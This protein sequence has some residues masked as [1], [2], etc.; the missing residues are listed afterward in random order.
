MLE[1]LHVIR[2]AK[3][4][5]DT[6]HLTGDIEH[7]VQARLADVHADHHHPLAK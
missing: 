6:L 4:V 2:V 7:L 3:V 5:R 1:Q